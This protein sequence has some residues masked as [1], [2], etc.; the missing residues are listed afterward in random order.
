MAD[1]PE[2]RDVAAEGEELGDRRERDPGGVG[3]DDAGPGVG[4]DAE[5]AAGD[6]EHRDGRRRE[7]E[8]ERRAP[9]DHA[10]IEG[11]EGELGS[12]V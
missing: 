7:R 5:P 3:G 10:E 4:D 8:G 9:G 6:Q 12:R 1:E 2:Q 11:G